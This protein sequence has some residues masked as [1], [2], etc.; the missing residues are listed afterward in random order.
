MQ[1]QKEVKSNPKQLNRKKNVGPLEGHCEKRCKIQ[2]GSQEMAVMVKKFNNDNS[3]EFGA[4]SYVE[5]AKQIHL[6]YHY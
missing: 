5:K 2:G 1:L 6:N 4:K 3:G